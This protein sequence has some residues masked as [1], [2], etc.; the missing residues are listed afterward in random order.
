MHLLFTVTP[1]ANAA[2]RQQTSVLSLGG[3]RLLV[4]DPATWAFLGALFLTS[5]TKGL[6]EGLGQGV[7]T[8]ILEALGLIKRDSGDFQKY[9][10]S[11]AEKIVR[12]VRTIVLDNEVR[13][14]HASLK[15]GFD[16]F[17]GYLRSPETRVSDLPTLDVYVGDSYQQLATLGA[18]ALPGF[19][20]A[21]SLLIAVRLERFRTSQSAGEAD[22]AKSTIETALSDLDKK[23]TELRSAYDQRVAGPY[24]M[25]ESHRCRRPRTP[26]DPGGVD[27]VLLRA[28][29]CT[30]DG[31]EFSA[32]LEDCRGNRLANHHLV[33]ERCRNA[34]N[35]LDAD[36]RTNYT[37][38]VDALKAEAAKML[39]ELARLRPQPQRAEA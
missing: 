36:F 9:L 30:V 22:N 3:P 39:A 35:G 33:E 20:G 10:D 37:E 23:L 15:N 19:L 4:F 2:G 27:E 29:A 11:L 25:R 16:N 18:S 31:Q 1:D 13:R 28:I 7:A 6:G 38:P 5:F 14:A 26:D 8:S 24:E 32:L 17:E 34:R 12:D 21:A